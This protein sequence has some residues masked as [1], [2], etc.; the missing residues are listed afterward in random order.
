[1]KHILIWTAAL[2]LLACPVYA[3]SPKVEAAIKSLGK[4][5]ADAAKF[6]EFCRITKELAEVGEDAAKSEALDK[7]LEELLRIL[8]R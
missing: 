1:M 8:R 3:A 6:K 2:G 5:E 4:I 7:Q